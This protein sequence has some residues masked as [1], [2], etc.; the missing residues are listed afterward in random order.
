MYITTPRII[1]GSQLGFAPAAVATAAANVFSKITSGFGP[2]G[3]FLRRDEMRKKY[4]E[5]AGQYFGP[6]AVNS[7]PA[8]VQKW[9]WPAR[10][11]ILE[12][13]KSEG[14][15]YYGGG[16]EEAL[17]ILAQYIGELEARLNEAKQ[18]TQQA[19]AT[20]GAAPLA[21]AALALF[22]LKG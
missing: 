2:S 13:G 12:I 19:G 4:W 6:P 7:Y 16:S 8:D 1:T 3:A 21:L 10:D 5:V 17:K 14:G 11:K 20:G 22:A 9:A 18:T 15:P